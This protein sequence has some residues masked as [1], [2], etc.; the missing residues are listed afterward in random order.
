MAVIEK[1]EERKKGKQQKPKRVLAPH[2]A[3]VVLWQTAAEKYFTFGLL[4]ICWA[5]DEQKWSSH[6]VYKGGSIWT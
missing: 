2:A 6:W 1:K 3:A 5:S 4:F